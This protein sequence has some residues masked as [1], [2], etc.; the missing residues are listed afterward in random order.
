VQWAGHKRN[1]RVPECREMLDSLTNSVL[2]VDPNMNDSLSLG[3]YVDE[4]ERIMR[5]TDDSIRFGS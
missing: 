3:P 2:M 5:R 4:D 1:A